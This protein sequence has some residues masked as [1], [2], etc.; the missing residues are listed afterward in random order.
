MQDVPAEDRLNRALRISGGLYGAMAAENP[1]AAAIASPP[2]APLI[3]PSLIAK[4]TGNDPT[5]VGAG[6]MGAAGEFVTDP[7]TYVGMG[8]PGELAAAAP[9]GSRLARILETAD[10]YDKLP[11]V[12]FDKAVAGVQAGA[13]RAGTALDAA[14]PALAT[15]INPAKWVRPDVQEGKVVRQSNDLLDYLIATSKESHFRKAAREA[16]GASESL[17]RQD[18]NAE[19]AVIDA[20]KVAKA[21]SL[22]Q[23]AGR[24]ATPDDILN[25]LTMPYRQNKFMDGKDVIQHYMDVYQNAYK[26]APN[27]AVRVAV[28]EAMR[29]VDV[30]NKK[31]WDATYGVF[32]SSRGAARTVK[33]AAAGKAAPTD[34]NAMY[35][36]AMDGIR[37]NMQ[38]GEDAIQDAVRAFSNL[39]LTDVEEQSLT[40]LANKTK[41]AMDAARKTRTEGVFPVRLEEQIPPSARTPKPTMVGGVPFSTPIP[42]LR[43]LMRSPKD[44]MGLGYYEM[45]ERIAQESQLMDALQAQV[46]AFLGPRAPE[47]EPARIASMMGQRRD[48]MAQILQGKPGALAWLPQ[49]PQ[50]EI[51]SEIWNQLV[52]GID[53]GSKAKNAMEEAFGRV[54]TARSGQAYTPLAAGNQTPEKILAHLNNAVADL[55]ASGSIPAPMAINNQADF[56]RFIRGY[57][58]TDEFNALQ[59]TVKPFRGVDLLTTDPIA[60]SYDRAIR[61]LGPSY[62]ITDPTT[63][64]QKAWASIG[65]LH[66]GLNSLYKDMALATTTYPL[67]N[68]LGAMANHA[69]SGLNPFDAGNR[70]L[71]SMAKTAVNPNKTHYPESMDNLIAMT[72]E[73]PYGAARGF[74]SDLASQTSQAVR[75]MNQIGTSKWEQLLPGNFNLGPIKGNA[76][77]GGAGAVLGATGGNAQLPAD[78]TDDERNRTIMLSALVGA[79]NLGVGFPTMSKYVKRLALGVEDAARGA[80]WEHA[81][82]GTVVDNIPRYQQIIE[83]A[84]SKGYPV[85][86]TKRPVG[87]P[88][89]QYPVQMTGPQAPDLKKM[90]DA[91]ESQ[92]YMV[93]PQRLNQ[94]LTESGVAESART[95]AVQE[96]RLLNHQANA[97]GQ[98][99]AGHIQFDYENLNNFEELMKQAIPFST[100]VMKANPFFARHLLEKPIIF[101]TLVR[102][103]HDF[104][105]NKREHGLTG[106][107]S[108]ASNFGIADAFWSSLL[109]HNVMAFYNPLKSMFP[110]SN[111]ARS[112]E[113]RPGENTYESLLR[114]ADLYGIPQPGPIPAA[115]GRFAGLQGD[116]PPPSLIRSAAPVQGITAALG[117]N[118]GQGVDI[119][120]GLAS[121]E[122][123]F[124]RGRGQDVADSTTTAAQGRLAEIYLATY[125][126]T[127]A[128]GGPEAF[129]FYQAIADQKGPLWDHAMRQ[130]AQE[131]GTRSILGAT[132]GPLSPQAL[133]TG[134]EAQ[135]RQERKNQQ[136]LSPEFSTR[137]RKNAALNPTGAASPADV[138]IMRDAALYFVN[139]EFG[140]TELPSKAQALLDSGT[141]HGVNQV[142]KDLTELQSK[143]HP[144]TAAYVT[145][146]GADEA[147]LQALLALQA[148]GALQFPGGDVLMRV[149]QARQDTGLTGRL[150]NEGHGLAGVHMLPAAK[151]RAAREALQQQHPI[152]AAYEGWR[153][154][155]PDGGVD[156]FLKEYRE[157]KLK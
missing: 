111:T 53:Q 109:G 83:D 73:Q 11:A 156:E 21:E 76:T 59:S 147:Q 15:A 132:L 137:I 142:R 119:G 150:G 112:T 101:A 54:Y 32:N 33:G 126:Q 116:A 2:L 157:D 46:G 17:I 36:E 145:T 55:H 136:V 103:Q 70:M 24:S 151:A 14:S 34:T 108:G 98:K 93:S 135:I 6:A 78:A 61:M 146:G 91:I 16:E 84:F 39:Q 149:N 12:L 68:A 81:F 121:A 50:S 139:R 51:M 107:V 148:H 140:L 72:G 48:E 27:A 47:V 88:P 57:G 155:H 95:R 5:Q 86:T 75:E 92:G 66:E 123:D 125:G 128:E 28:L 96:W 122:R 62:G 74:A 44:P 3:V 114:L 152:L 30:A 104:D 9:Q 127:L 153:L 105:Q 37:F 110:W 31:V 79:A 58:S 1:L 43:R 80:E 115:I 144:L 41:A 90:L 120:A 134:E 49:G 8:I 63:G 69:L 23:N 67:V 38:A 10:R 117:L 65:A 106:R 97:E 42:N 35:K 102:M 26:D 71:R 56:M 113:P 52:K 29:Q 87:K 13:S 19:R 20:K 89:E 40:L 85:T 143:S 118:R 100:Y 77:L 124:R 133:V 130:I 99:L 154:S 60:A 131:K 64:P 129:P 18:Y 94:M 138:E 22:A 141:N 25:S 7:L 45:E 4:A 82:R